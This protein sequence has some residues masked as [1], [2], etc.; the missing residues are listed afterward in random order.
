MGPLVCGARGRVPGA[1]DLAVL[2]STIERETQYL[3]LV[4][5]DAPC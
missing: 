1:V 2:K 4:I 3:T 5:I